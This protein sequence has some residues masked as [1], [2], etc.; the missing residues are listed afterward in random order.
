MY[1]GRRAMFLAF[2]GRLVRLQ[3]R[4]RS[5]GNSCEESGTGKNWLLF[6][7]SQCHSITAAY[8]STYYPGD[9][10]WAQQAPQ[11]HVSAITQ[12][13]HIQ[14][15]SMAARSKVWVCGPSLS[16]VAGSNP[17]GCIEF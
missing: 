14:Q 4:V 16:G 2:N 1:I 7:L 6:I 15:I 13:T 3:T 8:L 12:H 17:T 5:Q 11:F 10:Q 9:G